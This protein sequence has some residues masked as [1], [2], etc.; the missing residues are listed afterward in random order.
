V[1]AFGGVGSAVRAGPGRVV[2]IEGQAGT[3]KTRLVQEA[4]RILAPALPLFLRSRGAEVENEFAFGVVR[5]L[6][7]A[8]LSDSETAPAADEDVSALFGRPAGPAGAGEP[9][10]QFG[11][12]NTLYWWAVWLS[13]RRPLVLLV[14]DAQWADAPSLRFL[15][16]LARRLE[17][18]PVAVIVA[19]RPAEMSEPRQLLADL[20]AMPWT[21]R[22]RP[23][24]LSQVAVAAVAAA[25]FGRTPAP[26][27]VAACWQT[28]AGNPLFVHEL[29]RLLNDRGISPAADAVAAVRESGPVAV[30]AYVESRLAR[31]PDGVRRLAQAV[32][33][34]GPQTALPVAAEVAS[35]AVDEAGE[36]AGRL[37]RLGVFAQDADLS[38]VHP[39]LQAAVYEGLP[40]LDRIRLHT[41]AA[42]AL[43]RSG[44]SAERQSAHI[45]HLPPAAD[46]RRLK[47]LLDAAAWARSRCAVDAAA[48]YLRRAAQEPPPEPAQSE[49][50]RQLGN[51]EAY[52]LAVPAAEDHLRRSVSLARTSVQ[53]ALSG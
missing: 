47:V 32:A 6:F 31:Q 37:H 40:A 17:R 46:Q 34:L 42:E 49:I 21:V 29:V 3:G 50:F 28:T 11:L 41:A 45:L 39:L 35:L 27:F 18:I 9:I 23:S 22:L 7:G 12:L 2:A 20:S 48:I 19:W 25:E 53:Q 5:Q 44:A 26:D 24:A 4:E 16:F 30:A 43:G 8:L 10:S 13:D 1:R 52:V 38:Y 15:G 33:V 14:D 51:S 36:S